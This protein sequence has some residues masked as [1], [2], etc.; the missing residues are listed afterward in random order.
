MDNEIYR[1][2][3]HQCTNHLI[4][5]YRLTRN[6]MEYEPLWLVQSC[7]WF[8]VEPPKSLAQ[9]SVKFGDTQYTS[10]PPDI[11]DSYVTQN[12]GKSNAIMERDSQTLNIRKTSRQV[13]RLGQTRIPAFRKTI[14]F[15]DQA[16]WKMHH[17]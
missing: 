7:Q 9:N 16:W 2:Q 14:S 4:R 3:I 6:M 11:K 5:D 15:G 17:L 12:P 10:S 1:Q 8:I 13:N